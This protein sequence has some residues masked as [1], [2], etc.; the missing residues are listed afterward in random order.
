[1][2]LKSA[3]TKARLYVFILRTGVLFLLITY[4]L[5]SNLTILEVFNHE[6][7]IFM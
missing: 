5:L 2:L 4:Q 3:A 1:M 7:V 6:R